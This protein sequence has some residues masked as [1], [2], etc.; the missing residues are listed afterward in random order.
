MSRSQNRRL[1]SCLTDAFGE[2][3]LLVVR[4]DGT[5]IEGAELAPGSAL[6]WPPCTCG[7][8]ICPARPSDE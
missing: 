5:F 6:D 7:G 1:L 8:P 3:G 2:D 4:T